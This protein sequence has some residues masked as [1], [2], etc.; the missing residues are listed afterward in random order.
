MT[1]S[2][3]TVTSYT[4]AVFLSLCLAAFAGCDGQLEEPPPTS[5]GEGF[6]RM[7]AVTQAADGT[8]KAVE[9]LVP[10]DTVRAMHRART[11]RMERAQRGEVVQ[12]QS[13]LSFLGNGGGCSGCSDIWTLC[14][15]D[16][17]TWLY[18]HSDGWTLNLSHSSVA[19]GCFGA[20]SG[21][22][23]GSASLESAT[24]PNFGAT[25]KATVQSMW[26]SNTF[27]ADLTGT[28]PPVTSTTSF[29]PF[30]QVNLQSNFYHTITHVQP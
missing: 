20:G 30:Q 22:W 5:G 6:V 21:S 8:Q 16:R 11:E 4:P 9:Q 18:N 3:R 27:R 17:T 19:V 2:A 15:D 26:V 28:Q 1:K 13:A 25:W 23:T 29:S 7:V 24:L 12:Q 10:I 14:G